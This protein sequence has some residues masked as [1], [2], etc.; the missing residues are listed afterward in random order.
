MVN[1]EELNSKLDSV[2]DSVDLQNDKIDSIADFLYKEVKKLNK[3]LSKLTI[4]FKEGNHGMGHD[5]KE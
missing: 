4:K 1:K 2:R 5:R 3:N